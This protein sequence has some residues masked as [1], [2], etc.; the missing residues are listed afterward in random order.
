MLGACIV[1]RCV[2]SCCTSVLENVEHVSNE[3]VLVSLNEP[4]MV[5]PDQNSTGACCVSSNALV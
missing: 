3:C 1:A 2:Y 5:R 4:P